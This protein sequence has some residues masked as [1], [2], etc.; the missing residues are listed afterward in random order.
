MLPM[1]MIQVALPD[2]DPWKMLPYAMENVA[3]KRSMNF[4]MKNVAF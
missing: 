1:T 2:S 3:L 4:T